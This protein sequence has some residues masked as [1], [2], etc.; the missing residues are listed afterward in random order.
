MR[1]YELLG[2][3]C[4]LPDHIWVGSEE[5]AAMTGLSLITFQQRRTAGLPNPVA[6]LRLLRWH[7][8]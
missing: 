3:L 1:D 2:Y 6:G 7:F 4:P 5:V 8:G